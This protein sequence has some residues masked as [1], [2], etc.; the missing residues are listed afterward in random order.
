M[1]GLARID[2]RSWCQNV[3]CKICQKW[4][5]RHLTP[6]RIRQKYPE[7]V[8]NRGKPCR[9]GKKK[10][11]NQRSERF[12]RNWYQMMEITKSL[13]LHVGQKHVPTWLSS[14][15]FCPIYMNEN[16]LSPQLSDHFL[17]IFRLWS[18]R[19]VS[20]RMLWWPSSAQEMC[21]VALKIGSDVLVTDA[22]SY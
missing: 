4:R 14:P 5:W 16:N 3:W 19:L 18:S 12:F 22:M 13:H 11:S 6:P 8:K 7:R 15:A 1:F 21:N 2:L 17:H 20:K 9:V 10:Q